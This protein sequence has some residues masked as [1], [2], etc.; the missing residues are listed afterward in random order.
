MDIDND[1]TLSKHELKVFLKSLESNVS[2]EQITLLLTQFD[3]NG[4]G[5]ISFSEFKD[6]LNA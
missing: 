2:D 6:Y 5:V 3:A 1:G 4:D